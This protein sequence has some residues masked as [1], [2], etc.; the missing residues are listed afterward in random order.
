MC[1]AFP[2]CHDAL[3]LTLLPQEAQAL[4]G[5]VPG[6][7]RSSQEEQ[8]VWPPPSPLPGHAWGSGVILSSSV[9]PQCLQKPSQPTASTP[10]ACKYTTSGRRSTSAL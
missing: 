5:R 8:V 1:M 7:A 6:Q 9:F 10:S 3:R 2:A 4:T